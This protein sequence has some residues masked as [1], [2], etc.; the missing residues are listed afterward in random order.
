MTISTS[1]PRKQQYASCSS[2]AA[3]AASKAVPILKAQEMSWRVT[4]LD[5]SGAAV[6][7]YQV[8]LVGKA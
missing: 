8:C 1:E 4:I 6:D 2:G 3:C 7:A 5:K